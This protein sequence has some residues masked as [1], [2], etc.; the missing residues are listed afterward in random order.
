MLAWPPGPVPAYDRATVP[1][2]RREVELSGAWLAWGL[3]FG[4]F[5]L[6]YFVYGK[7]QNR[8]VPM[9]CGLGLMVVPYLVSGTLALVAVGVVLVAIPWFVRA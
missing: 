9:L 4:S 2:R 8:A 7:K 5:G 3:V 1:V 6:G